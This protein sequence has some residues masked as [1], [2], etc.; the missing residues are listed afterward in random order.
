MRIDDEDT[1]DFEDLTALR[2]DSSYTNGM[3][4]ARVL[5]TVPC[6]KPPRD[7]FVRVHPGEDYRMVALIHEREEDRSIYLLDQ[8]IE[9]DFP[10]R[11]SHAVIYT[12]IT[13]SGV[14]FLWPAKLSVGG[15]PNTW[16]D[17]AQAAAR[18]AMGAWIRV[19]SNQIAKSYEVIEARGVIAIPDWSAV[20]CF[21]RLLT[22]AFPPAKVVK[23][24][25]HPLV[26]QLSGAI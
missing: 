25:N 7:Q 12:A 9:D 23:D 19:K 13:R 10:G 24:E 1:E 15:E 17:T 6:H 26:L 11:I 4:V 20:P 3:S 18:R 8:G 22:L 21:K 5:T 2:L 16:N 14:V